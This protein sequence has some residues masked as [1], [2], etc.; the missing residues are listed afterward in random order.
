M[1]DLA[2][3]ALALALTRTM[4]FIYLFIYF[5]KNPSW[6]GASSIEIALKT[7]SVQGGNSVKTILGL[8]VQGGN[9]CGS[10]EC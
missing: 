1:E 9:R 4:L 8:N 10:V 2:N 6:N 5:N 3:M 7:L